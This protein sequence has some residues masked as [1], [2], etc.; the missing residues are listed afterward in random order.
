MSEPPLPASGGPSTA[1]LAL[2]LALAGL[3]SG[4]ALVSAYEVTLP[5]ITANKAAAIKRAVLEV[6]PGSTQLRSLIWRDGALVASEEAGSDGFIYA[7]YDGAGAFRGYAIPGEGAGFQD[8][9]RLLY[10][11]D[12]SAGNVVGMAILESRETP[13][14]GDKIYKDA[15]F[16]AEFDALAV[17][18]E[19][20]ATK[21]PSG[22]PNE[23]DAITGAT[24]S[25]KA[26]VRIINGANAV[27][28]DR[29][30]PAGGEP[31]LEPP[32]A[33]NEAASAEP[34]G[35]R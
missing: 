26:V 7:A 25:S 3:L 8:A 11:F 6:V 29:L 13:G 28:R 34:G 27:W 30:P 14:L 16:V 24:I 22:A 5:R 19:I 10:G 4:L 31:A 9:I 17:E 32:G 21:E 23:V 15:S 20:V 1:R 18:P 33:G 35:T 12:P 2:T